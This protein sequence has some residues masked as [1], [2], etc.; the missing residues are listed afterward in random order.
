MG[1]AAIEGYIGSNGLAMDKWD[2]TYPDGQLTIA[3][4]DTFSSKPFFQDLKS[5]VERAKRWR[6]LR[7]DSGDPKEFT[8]LAKSVYD[9]MGIDAKTS[10][11]AQ[12]WPGAAFEL[13]LQKRSST[14]MA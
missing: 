11:S 13:L 1:V 2:V 8:K 5:N 6:G 14:R 12:A 10:T 9:E 3:L 4:T 7:Q